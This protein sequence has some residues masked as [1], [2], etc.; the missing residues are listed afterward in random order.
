MR[1][2]PA[3]FPDA[4]GIAQKAFAGGGFLTTTSRNAP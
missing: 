3:D 4:S 2:T 1:L